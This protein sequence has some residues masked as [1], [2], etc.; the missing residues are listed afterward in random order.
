MLNMQEAEFP[1][2]IEAEITFLT[3][4][5]CGREM[6]VFSGYRPQFHYD[7][8]DFVAVNQ[9]IET[10]EAVCPGQTVKAY[11]AFTS[12]ELHVGRLYPGKEFLLREG[13]RIVARGRVTKVLNLEQS[14]QKRRNQK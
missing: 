4:E 10:V 8:E 6:P 3:F 7:G 14:A 1:K 9:F 13:Q 5:E 11:V 12:P 2:H